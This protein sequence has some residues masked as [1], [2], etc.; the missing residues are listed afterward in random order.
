MKLIGY[1]QQCL[2][3]TLPN[4]KVSN[5]FV[6]TVHANKQKDIVQCLYWIWH[7]KSF[8]YIYRP[9]FLGWRIQRGPKTDLEALLG[10]HG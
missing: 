1:F 2:K 7:Y 3:L 10:N 8:H 6:N 5:V 4:V 9:E